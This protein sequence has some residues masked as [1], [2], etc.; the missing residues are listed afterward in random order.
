MTNYHIEHIKAYLKSQGLTDRELMDDLTDHLATEIEFSMDSEKLDFETSFEIA[1][2]KL[3][4]N[5][6][7]QLER[8]LKILTT[9]KHNIM[10][11]KIAYIGGYISTVCLCISLVLLFNSSFSNKKLETMEIGLRMQ[12]PDIDN[13][14]FSTLYTDAYMKE[15]SRAYNQIILSQTMF[16]VSF[17][18]FA[19]TFLPY[20]FYHRY[21][22]SQ[23]EL[24]A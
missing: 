14:E 13:K 2:Q 22:K 12:Y 20:Q 9:Q 16:L 1:K 18:V 4:P 23:L 15:H 5:S 21:Q 6:P 17:V 8:D 7:Y 19:I 10:M 3:L 24:T 11:K